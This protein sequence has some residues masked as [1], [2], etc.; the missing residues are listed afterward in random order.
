[1]LVNLQKE[2]IDG[3][4]PNYMIVFVEPFVI[5]QH[6]FLISMPDFTNSSTNMTTEP[7]IKDIEVGMSKLPD[8]IVQYNLPEVHFQGDDP[9]A[10]KI[11]RECEKLQKEQGTFGTTRYL[12]DKIG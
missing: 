6:V 11:V 1:M 9:I 8:F 10:R 12:F 2:S 7:K 5:S 4:M 3:I